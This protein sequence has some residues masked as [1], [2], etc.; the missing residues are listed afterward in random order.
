MQDCVAG[1][2]CMAC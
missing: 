2:I 1:T